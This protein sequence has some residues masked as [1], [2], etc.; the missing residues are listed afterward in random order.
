[1]KWNSECFV[2]ALKHIP[3][4]PEYNNGMRQLVHVGY[5]IAA[6]MGERYL[7]ALDKYECIISQNVS[8]NILK[9][10]LEAV[11]G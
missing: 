8:D 6:E 7:D 1:M 10:H 5:K 9:R 3:S 2:N 11:F 4:H